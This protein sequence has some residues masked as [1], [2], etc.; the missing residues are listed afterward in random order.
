[1]PRTTFEEITQTAAADANY[2]ISGDSVALILALLSPFWL[3]SAPENEDAAQELVDRAIREL[4]TPIEREKRVGEIYAT[5]AQFWPVGHLPLDG[6]F[7]DGDEYSELFSVV[8]DHWRIVITGTEGEQIKTI[9][10]PNMMNNNYLSGVSPIGRGITFGQNSYSLT[11]SQL[12]PHSHRTR[13]IT[14]TTNQPQNFS[15]DYLLSTNQLTWNSG[16]T[17][18]T[19][20]GAPIDNRPL[21]LGVSWLIVA[22]SAV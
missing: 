9:M 22:T 20:N 5:I 2:A 10:L 21:S 1:M 19:G 15:I 8:P 17:E 16:Y 4:M 18:N 7:I 6:A 3:S 14:A 11:Q 13:G 12:P